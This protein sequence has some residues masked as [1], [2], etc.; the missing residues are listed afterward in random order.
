VNGNNVKNR[1]T[2]LGNSVQTNILGTLR[3]GHPVRNYRKGLI[4]PNRIIGGQVDTEVMFAAHIAMHE[5]L[6][7]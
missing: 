1:V 4:F 6:H 2:F 3:S 7:G 5:E